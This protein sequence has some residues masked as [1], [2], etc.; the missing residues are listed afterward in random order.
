VRDSQGAEVGDYGLAI[1]G[2]GVPVVM[3][4]NYPTQ[5]ALSTEGQDRRAPYVVLSPG[6][7][8]AFA[9]VPGVARGRHE[10]EIK[11]GGAARQIVI[12][13]TEAWVDSRPK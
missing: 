7:Y 11:P 9:H 5:F 3:M 1:Q 12:D 6:R 2:P 13:L 10:F 4:P 8:T